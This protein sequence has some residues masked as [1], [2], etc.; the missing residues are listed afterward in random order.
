MDKEESK[1][2]VC[3]FDR[4]ELVNLLRQRGVDE[5]II[6]ELL[7]MLPKDW[8]CRREA[9]DGDGKCIFHSARKNPN[10]FREALDKELKRMDEHKTIYDFIGFVFPEKIVLS[11][12]SD[13]RT[14]TNT[15]LFIG[16]TFERDV[17]FECAQFEKETYFMGAT[18][19]GTVNFHDAKFYSQT[20]FDAASF[21][22]D[23]YFS[24]AEFIENVSFNK[25][26]FLKHASF[27]FAVFN[28]QANFTDSQ[29]QDYV[30]FAK[31]SDTLFKAAH[32][33]K[34]T[35][36]FNAEFYGEVICNTSQFNGETTFNEAVFHKPVKLKKLYSKAPLLLTTSNSMILH[37]FLLRHSKEMHC[38]KRPYLNRM[39]FS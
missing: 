1:S 36:Y 13:M 31:F 18:F 9:Y 32:F 29:F 22:G 14:F 33:Q 21:E 35:S 11:E 12:M 7:T 15:T 3:T 30:D 27:R 6:K 4:N 26:K 24:W 28:K 39:L 20:K 17:F 8:S 19:K 38:L 5:N 34:T 16:A 25:T 10:E 2:N 23:A 37:L